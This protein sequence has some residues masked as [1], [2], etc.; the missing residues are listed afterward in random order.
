MESSTSRRKKPTETIRIVTLIDPAV[1]MIR[2]P[3]TSK[4][5]TTVSPSGELHAI[6]Y[7]SL[8]LVEPDNIVVGE[9]FMHMTSEYIRNDLCI[10]FLVWKGKSTHSI[11]AI[12]KDM[13][14]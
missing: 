9:V 8:D 6:V 14:N 4:V 12:V 1:K 3:E 2:H 11:K 7:G 5:L 10:K 13:F